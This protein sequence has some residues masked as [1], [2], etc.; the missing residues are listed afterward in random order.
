MASRAFQPSAV[1]KKYWWSG[2]TLIKRCANEGKHGNYQSSQ[3]G[4]RERKNIF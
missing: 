3:S 1:F 2:A 4:E